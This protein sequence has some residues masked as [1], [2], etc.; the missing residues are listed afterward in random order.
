MTMQSYAQASPVY[1]DGSLQLLH[2][3]TDRKIW[4]TREHNGK[5]YVGRLSLEDGTI[6]ENDQISPVPHRFRI[7]DPSIDER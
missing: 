6:V 2:I 3:E 1:E 7:H 4:A 5:G